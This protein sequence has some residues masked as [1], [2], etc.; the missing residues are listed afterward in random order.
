MS[1]NRCLSTTVNLHSLEAFFAWR[2]WITWSYSKSKSLDR[3]TG[4]SYRSTLMILQSIQ[5]SEP[6]LSIKQIFWM[7]VEQNNTSSLEDNTFYVFL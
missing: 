6:K 1:G 4:F 7:L 3:T 5:E 2:V